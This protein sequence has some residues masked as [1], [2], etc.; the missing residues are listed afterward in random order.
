MSIS[1]EKVSFAYGKKDVLQEVTWHLPETGVVG[2]WG[3][4]GCGKTT[5]LRL[6]AGLAKPASGT[7]VGARRVA[8][9]FQEDRLLPWRT[10]REN[11]TLVGAEDATACELLGAL[12][13]SDAEMN[14]YPHQ[15]SGGQQRRV[16]LARALA[17]DS[18]VV[19]LDE[20]FNG[21]DEGTWQDVIPL[22]QRV[23]QTRPVVLVTHIREQ[24]QALN[25]TVI[26]L[27]QTPQ[28]GEWQMVDFL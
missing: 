11:V 22:I 27:G 1:L 13:L 15:L 19:L 12:G 28:T 20:P 16:A 26:P 6:L 24:M 8:M 25:A 18:D 5:V 21:L 23:A 17:A 10:A 7:V 4:S 14:A 2:L 3:P 9:V